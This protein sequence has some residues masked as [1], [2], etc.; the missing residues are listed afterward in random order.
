M[1]KERNSNIG[2]IMAFILVFLVAVLGI[3]GTICFYNKSLDN[4]VEDKT[5]V[6]DNQCTG[7]NNSNNKDKITFLKKIEL[8]NNKGETEIIDNKKYEF[9]MLEKNSEYELY[10]NNK[11]IA[12]DLPM[13]KIYLTNKFIIVDLAAGMCGTHYVFFDY[14]GAKMNLSYDSNRYRFKDIEFK[15]NK[16]MVSVCDMNK[17]ILDGNEVGNLYDYEY[18]DGC[19]NRL[20][21]YPD[22]IQQY[23]DFI[24]EADYYLEYNNYEI[25]L[26]LDKVNL[27]VGDLSLDVCVSESQSIYEPT[28]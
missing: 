24:L 6:E 9:K 15:N 26:K 18:S 10:L 17:R 20:K 23:K 19:N 11:K 21:D 25:D 12:E 28:F 2:L 22:F 3:I 13:F 14:N 27:T 4:N 5:N 8:K 7:D 16:L 1:E